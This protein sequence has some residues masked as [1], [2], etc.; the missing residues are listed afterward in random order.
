MRR[1]PGASA[2][3]P[4]SG[5]PSGARWTVAAIS[6]RAKS[7]ADIIK[8]LALSLPGVPE[9]LQKQLLWP[10]SSALVLSL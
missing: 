7:Q 5:L 6:G 3:G 2:N 4:K 9:L 1:L 8:P 10:A